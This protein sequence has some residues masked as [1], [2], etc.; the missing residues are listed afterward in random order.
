MRTLVRDLPFFARYHE[1]VG[2]WHEPLRLKPFQI[3]LWISIT[4]RGLAALPADTPK[5]PVLL[6]TGHNHHLSLRDEHLHWSGLAMDAL[7][8][9]VSPLRVRDASGQERP[10]PRLYVDAW[11]HPNGVRRANRPHPLRLGAGGAACYVA[12]DPVTGPHLPLLGLRALCA[13]S[14]TMGLGCNPDG[15]TLTLRVPS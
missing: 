14:V 3:L 9:A 8:F 12:G 1:V 10:V 2:P 15:G 11:L 5:V 13:G 7:E 6:D 4:R